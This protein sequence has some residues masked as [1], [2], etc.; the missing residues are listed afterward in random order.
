MPRVTESDETTDHNISDDYVRHPPNNVED[1]PIAHTHPTK[2]S[3]KEPSEAERAPTPP[4]EV[5][6]RVTP[7]EQMAKFTEEDSLIPERR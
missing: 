3:S 4:E 7:L 1:H 5:G 2:T 6:R